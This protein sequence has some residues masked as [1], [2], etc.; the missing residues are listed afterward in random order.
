MGGLAPL[1]AVGGL[2]AGFVVGI[3]TKGPRVGPGLECRSRAGRVGL[4]VYL[5]HRLFAAYRADDGSVTIGA[6]IGSTFA[7]FVGL[8]LARSRVLQSAR[9]GLRRR[10]A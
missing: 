6:A 7:L 2:I 10:P 1:A 8:G 9:R 4:G 5:R 3:I